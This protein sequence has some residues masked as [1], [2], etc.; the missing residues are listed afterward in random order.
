MARPRVFGRIVEV[1]RGASAP[2]LRLCIG[3]KLANSLPKG[4]MPA[5]YTLTCPEPVTPSCC[6]AH[7]AGL[8]HS[9]GELPDYIDCGHTAATHTLLAALVQSIVSCASV[10]TAGVLRALFLIGCLAWLRQLV[11]AR[12]AGTEV[13]SHTREAGAWSKRLKQLK[14][15]WRSLLAC[16]DSRLVNS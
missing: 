5:A 12:A 4:P 7:Q 2:L 9:R 15:A 13:R 3:F 11:V 16:K 10:T 6:G 1:R 14:D 8:P